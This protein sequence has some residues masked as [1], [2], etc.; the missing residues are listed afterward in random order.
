LDSLY[1]YETVREP[2]FRSGT[3]E[4]IENLAQELKLPYEDYMQDWSYEVANP[5]DIEK[6]IEHYRLTEDEDKK[7]VLMEII[8]QAVNDQADQKDFLKYWDRIKET[9]KADFRIHEYTIFYW[10]CFDSESADEQFVISPGMQEIF[11]QH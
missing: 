3:K 4:A 7:F 5:D 11:R 1:N 6:Y 9:L 2:K 8:I 10:S